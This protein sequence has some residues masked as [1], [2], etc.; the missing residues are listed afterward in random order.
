MLVGEVYA[1]R[2]LAARSPPT[3]SAGSPVLGTTIARTERHVSAAYRSS[4]E[5]PCRSVSRSVGR[6]PG[7]PAWPG[8][9]LHSPI[10][11]P[12]ARTTVRTELR[13]ITPWIEV[14]SLDSGH[15]GAL[16]DV[17]LQDEEDDEHG[18]DDHDR[19]GQQQAVLR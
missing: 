2:L 18:D 8:V 1:A 12:S 7:G 5:D 15:G 16:H 10:D 13:M 11:R 6:S 14:R 17:A 9:G 19:A 4:T 3:L